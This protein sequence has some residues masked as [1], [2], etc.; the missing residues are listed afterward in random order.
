MLDLLLTFKDNNHFDYI[1]LRWLS[2]TAKDWNEVYKQAYRCYKPGGWIE[3]IDT[4]TV[5]YSED[6]SVNEKHAIVQWSKV[7]QEAGRRSGY[8]VDLLDKNRMEEGMNMKAAGFTNIVSKD[9][10]S[11]GLLRT[12]INALFISQ[13]ISQH[14][15]DNGVIPPR[16][17]CHYGL[18]TQS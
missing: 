14:E 18:R 1:H 16:F 17:L 15:A 11:A 10:P 9:Y 12:L 2:S 5:C 13:T 6:G 8:P 3:H 7:W 4:S